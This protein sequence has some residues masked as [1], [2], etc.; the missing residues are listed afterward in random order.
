VIAG[1]ALLSQ[2]FG[3]AADIWSVTSFTELRREGLSISRW[4]RLHP[5]AT[6]RLSYVETCLRDHKGPI[7][8]ATDYMKVYA[9]QIRPF[10]PNRHY[11]VLG[12]DGYGR[13]DTRAKLRRFFEVDR[14]YIAVAAL[15]ALAD[16]GRIKPAQVTEAI[17]KYSLD[18]EKPDPAT[19]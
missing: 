19:V 17:K 8:A 2:D 5:E 18:P 13:S 12:T 14:Y 3:V 10:I 9:D 1:A 11:L 16:E 15:K 6:P 7:V 4:N